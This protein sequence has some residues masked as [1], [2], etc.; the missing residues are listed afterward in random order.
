MN[1]ITVIFTHCRNG[2][3][4]S[5]FIRIKLIQFAIPRHSSSSVFFHVINIY[6]WKLL[7]FL[8]LII[9]IAVSTVSCKTPLGNLL[10]TINTHIFLLNEDVLFKTVRQ[11][12]A[13]VRMVRMMIHC[14]DVLYMKVVAEGGGCKGVILVIWDFKYQVQEAHFR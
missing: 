10:N 12:W 3:P 4:R 13:A 11:K 2:C 1:K 14:F 9:F 7:L 8:Y 6:L 5:N